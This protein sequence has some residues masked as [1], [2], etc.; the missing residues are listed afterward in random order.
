MKE[1]NPGKKLPYE[2]PAVVHR[3]L[4]ESIAGMCDS[5]DPVNG[6]TGAGDNCTVTNS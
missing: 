5:Q 2:K 4:M 3:E 6:K 1:L